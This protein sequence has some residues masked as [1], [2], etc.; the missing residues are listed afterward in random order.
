MDRLTSMSV[1][2]RVVARHSFVGAAHEL[3]LSRAA[4]SKHVLALEKSQI[5]LV[6]GLLALVRV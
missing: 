3:R 4:V 2:V 1:F 5:P 6:C